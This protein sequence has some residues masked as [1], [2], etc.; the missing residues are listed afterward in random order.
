MAAEQAAP[1]RHPGAPPEANVTKVESILA[2]LANDAAYLAARGLTVDEYRSALPAAI[3]KIRGSRAASNSNRRQFLVSLFEE[4]KQRGLISKLEMPRYGADTVY[5]LSI[6]GFGDV[7]VIQKGCPDG[8]HSSVRWTAPDW[9][10][11]TYLWWLCSSLT[12]EPGEHIVKGTN[13]LRQRFFSSAAD[14]LDGVIFHNEL[15]G[16][17]ERPCPKKALAIAVDDMLV[18]PPCIYV[19]PEHRKDGVEWNWDGAQQR[20]FPSILLSLFNIEPSQSTAYIG[21]VGFQK[22][23]GSLRST[24]AMP[25]GPGRSTNFR[26]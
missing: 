23:G 15:C 6:D 8:A 11:E 22:R 24:I 4:M 3:E 20:F 26:S 2:S 17:S 1:C 21:S 14:A 19:M 10:K 18:P 25:F 9:A 13:R 7:A 5:R 12:Y 16:S